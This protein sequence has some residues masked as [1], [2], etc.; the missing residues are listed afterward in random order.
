MASSR[1]PGKVCLP[2]DG[3]PVIEHII[4]RARAADLVDEV[5]VATTFHRRDD[6]IV[7]HA[8][9]VGVEA[10]R[11]SEDDV[12]GRLAGAAASFDCEHIVRLTGDNPFVDPKL[13]DRVAKP[14]VSGR[15]DYASNKIMRT[16]PLGVDAEAFTSFVLG[17]IDERT[18]DPY[19]REHVTPVM[20]DPEK[21]TER[22]ADRFARENVT[23]EDTYGHDVFETV[24]D[25]TRPRMTLDVPQDYRVFEQVY[26]NVQ[27]DRILDVRDA[28]EYILREGLDEVNAHVDQKTL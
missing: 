12:L 24:E 8:N 9:R 21:E 2:L 25:V 4:R 3:V 26:E 6:L 18:D 7:D 27:Y 22:V 13:I 11:G 17:F 1:L 5:V 14:V 15:A 23:V 10:F 28:V 20:Y 19:H 16:F